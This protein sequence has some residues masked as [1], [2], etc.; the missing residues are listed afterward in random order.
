MLRVCTR[1]TPSY[2]GATCRIEVADGWRR[3][4]GCANVLY[5]LWPGLAGECLRFNKFRD[6]DAKTILL[7]QY[8]VSSVQG[9]MTFPPLFHFS[10]TGPGAS[11]ADFIRGASGL[12]R[13]SSEAL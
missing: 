4:I 5:E 10:C 12:F 6:Y 8:E 1:A 2:L 7:S 3:L 13:G 9:I 11:G